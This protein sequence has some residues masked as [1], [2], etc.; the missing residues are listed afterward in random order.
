MSPA[1]RE[2]RVNLLLDEWQ[3]APESERAE[4][5]RKLRELRAFFTLWMQRQA[6]E[7]LEPQ[8]EPT[9]DEEMENEPSDDDIIIA[10]SRRGGYGAYQSGH[11]IAR[12]DEWDDLLW[13]IKEYMDQQKFWPNVWQEE[14]RGGFHIVDMS[15]VQKSELPIK[16]K[17]SY[18]PDA[19]DFEMTNLPGSPWHTYYSIG[20]QGD[21]IIFSSLPAN[22]PQAG[23]E[24]VR[25]D[26][27]E[28]LMQLEDGTIRDAK[29][30]PARMPIPEDAPETVQD[31]PVMDSKE[32]QQAL[33]RLLDQY[34]KADPELRQHLERKI[35]ELQAVRRDH[36]GWLKKA[37]GGSPEHPCKECGKDMGMAYFL[38]DLG[39]CTD[40]V[41]KKHRD[42]TEPGWRKKKAEMGP[43]SLDDVSREITGEDYKD[44]PD[45]G[46][47]QDYVMS[48]YE[49]QAKESTASDEPE[50]EISE[51]DRQKRSTAED[52]PKWQGVWCEECQIKHDKNLHEMEDQRR[53][54]ERIHDREK[55]LEKG[56]W[57][58]NAENGDLSQFECVEGD[59][60]P[61]V[62]LHG[63]HMGLE[64]CC[65]QHPD[66]SEED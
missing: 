22:Q 23:A 15:D 60:R 28:V 21:D 41:R 58:K 32:R 35:R 56:A 47:E 39:I 11:E 34:S 31:I 64:P 3:E 25:K 38:D 36:M 27:D 29:S 51:Y 46:P 66:C 1:D 20:R 24:H 61:A 44:L 4:I 13:E 6:D 40:C 49:K 63:G 12:S 26:L 19:V 10:D 37:D 9:I 17:P 30:N 16:S 50:N 53:A 59:G 48:E 45:D 57:L 5:E 54:W 52:Q 18:V 65:G 2:R 55:T 14:E 8:D 42:V 33:D 43:K 62:H 7:E